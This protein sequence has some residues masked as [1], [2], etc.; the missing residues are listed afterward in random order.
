MKHERDLQ[1]QTR[2]IDREKHNKPVVVTGLPATG[3]EGDLIHVGEP[4]ATP[5]D[6][7]DGY[8]YRLHGQMA[9]YR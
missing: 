5:T 7:L 6:A 4:P 1:A 3:E 9:I 2:R 8:Y